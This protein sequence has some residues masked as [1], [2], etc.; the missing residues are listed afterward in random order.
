MTTTASNHAAVPSEI[1]DD[2]LSSFAAKARPRRFQ[3]ASKPFHQTATHRRRC[4]SSG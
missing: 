4:R 1:W 3:S 2:L